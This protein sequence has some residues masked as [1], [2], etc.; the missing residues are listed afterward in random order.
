[1]NGIS[2]LGSGD[3]L[4]SRPSGTTVLDF[5]DGSVT[6]IVQV[7]DSRINSSDKIS[8]ELSTVVTEDHSLQDLLI[9]P[10]RLMSY[11]AITG[12]GFTIYGQ[13]DNA[14]A[15]GTYNINWYVR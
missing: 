5:G 12:S 15:N 6:A 10:I 13:M 4:L 14:P 8:V 7:T 11:G 3:L 1:M 2:L 9:D